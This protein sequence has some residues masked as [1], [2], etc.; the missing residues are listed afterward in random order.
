MQGQISQESPWEDS[1][2]F[3]IFKGFL[4]IFHVSTCGYLHKYS[5]HRGQEKTSDPPELDLQAAVSLPR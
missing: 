1:F 5:A 2:F 3:F 4:S